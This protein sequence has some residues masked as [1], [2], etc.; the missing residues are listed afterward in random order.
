MSSEN[1]LLDCYRTVRTILTFFLMSRNARKLINNG[2]RLSCKCRPIGLLGV[3]EKFS[4]RQRRCRN[5]NKASTV[6]MTSARHDTSTAGDHEK[7]AVSDDVDVATSWPEFDVDRQRYLH[8]G[9]TSQSYSCSN[10]MLMSDWTEFHCSDCYPRESING[11][12][13]I[14]GLLNFRGKLLAVHNDKQT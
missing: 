14:K 2:D 10:S 11:I 6:K 1:Y 5:P 9:W 8:I 12:I 4:V 3:F 7:P 13:S